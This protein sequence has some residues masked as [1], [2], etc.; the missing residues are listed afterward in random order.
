MQ[1]H[2]PSRQA[3]SPLSEGAKI[4]IVIWSDTYVSCI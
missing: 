2:S 4:Y 1:R 3:D